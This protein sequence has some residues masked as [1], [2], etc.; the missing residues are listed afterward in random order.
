MSSY[1]NGKRSRDAV[2]GVRLDAE[3]LDGF[4]RCVELNGGTTSAV[5]R[6]AIECV[7]DGER[8][9]ENGDLED[10]EDLEDAGAIAEDVEDA[11]AVLED[12]EELSMDGETTPADD[13]LD[14]AGHVAIGLVLGGFLSWVLGFFR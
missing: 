6:D 1:R 11:G 7:L 10:A 14:V 8:R 9:R 4:R 2:L 13:D 3:T 5:M 12:T